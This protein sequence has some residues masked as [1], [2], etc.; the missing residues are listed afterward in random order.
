MEPGLDERHP[1]LRLVAATATV[2]DEPVG[3]ATATAERRLASALAAGGTGS[4]AATIEPRA[5]GD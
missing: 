2:L 3:E 5:A 4:T 1:S